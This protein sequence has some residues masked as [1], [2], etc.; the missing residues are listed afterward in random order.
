[1]PKKLEG[2]SEE[3]L[4]KKMEQN[5]KHQQTYLNKDSNRELFNLKRRQAYA[6]KKQQLLESLGIASPPPPV[7]TPAPTTGRRA[8]APVVTNDDDS[9]E[10]EEEVQ[11]FKYS[12]SNRT[13]DLSQIKSLSLETC[14]AC[15]KILAEKTGMSTKGH[16]GSMRR[17]VKI[18]NC[19]DILECIN[20]HST[21]II[22]EIVNGTKVNKSKQTTSNFS[23][24]TLKVTFDS[25]CYIIERMLLPVSRAILQKFKNKS[26]EYGVRSEKQQAERQETERIPKF[27]DYAK[28][29]EEVFGKNSDMD[30]ITAIYKEIHGGRDDLGL[31]VVNSIDDAKPEWG[32]NYIVVRKVKKP[33]PIVSVRIIIDKFKTKND[34]EGYNLI[35]NKALSKRIRDYIKKNK[36]EYGDYLFGV[37]KLSSFINSCNHILRE[38]HNFLKDAAGGVNLFRKM[39]ASGE[40]FENM[41]P[42]EQQKEALRFKHSIK[43]HRLYLR[44]HTP[45]EENNEEN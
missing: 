11:S 12:K 41:T 16:V 32:D 33:K 25:I 1:M 7:T 29:V 22:D 31:R 44:L 37:E 30:L 6:L 36:V 15:L 40:E 10:D 19:N 35:V 9:S 3:V 27:D 45:E 13:L 21:K 43:T 18:T 5:R 8:A 39:L 38:Q 42:A 26:A 2:S 14:E 28:K 20:K 34:Y 24:N 4:A 23:I 17:V